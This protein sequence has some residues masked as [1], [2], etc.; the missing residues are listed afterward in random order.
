MDA[1]A[2]IFTTKILGKIWVATGIVSIL[3]VDS[4]ALED[5][6]ACLFFRVDVIIPGFFRDILM[7]CAD[8]QRSMLYVRGEY[9]LFP[10]NH[11]ERDV[12]DRSIWCCS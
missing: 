12:V 4:C 3:L 1:Y 2:S 9:W 11:E 10:T 8:T 7:I 5:D 6:E